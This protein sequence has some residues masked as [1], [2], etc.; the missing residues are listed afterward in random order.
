MVKDHFHSDNPPTQ[1]F[2]LHLIRPLLEAV[3]ACT[4]SSWWTAP[5]GFLLWFCCTCQG[6]TARRVIA[7]ILTYQSRRSTGGINHTSD[8]CIMLRRCARVKCML[9]MTPKGKKPL[10][11]LLYIHMLVMPWKVKM[12]A[13][14]RVSYCLSLHP[15]SLKSMNLDRWVHESDGLFI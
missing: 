15:T 3:W 2:S 7:D 4:D 10:L 12:S 5:L 13:G 8:S 6:G 11:M 1:V 14:T 9:K